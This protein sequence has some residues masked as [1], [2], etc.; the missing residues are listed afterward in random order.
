M[1]TDQVSSTPSTTQAVAAEVQSREPGAVPAAP[2]GGHAAAG[3]SD[4]F[5]VAA[6]VSR[7]IPAPFRHIEGMPLYRPLR[8]M[9]VDPAASQLEGAVARVNVPYEN[10]EP[11]PCG[12][13]FKVVG[14]DRDRDERY[15]P[16]DLDQPFAMISHGY[17]PSPSDPRFHQQ[18]VYAVCSAVYSTFRNALGRQVGWGFERTS[19]PERLELHP[20]AFRGLNAHY[21]RVAGALFFGYDLAGN[22]HATD[23][24]L[25]GGFVFTCLSHDVVVHELT[26]AML[27]GLRSHFSIPGSPDVAAFHE[28]FA[29]LVAI[30]QRLS[31]KELVAVA[32]RKSCG[33]LERA[34]LLTDLAKQLGHASGM[35][36]ALRSAL[37]L[38]QARRHS[39]D[40]DPHVMGSVLVAAVFEAYVTVFHR[41][42]ARYFRL[43]TQGTGIPARGELPADLAEVL[44][45]SVSKLASQF[46]SLIIRAIDFCPPVDIGFGEYLRALIT[47]DRDLVPDDRWGYREAL[48]DA[49]L[50]RDIYPRHVASL[51]EDALLWRQPCRK[52]PRVEQLDFAH[53]QFAGDPGSAAGP[54][55]LERQARVLGE[56]V[57]RPEYLGDFGLVRDGDPCLQGGVAELP[58]VASIRTARRVGPNGQIVFD[59]VAE[60][61]QRCLIPRT[62]ARAAFTAYGGAT[63]I[64]SPDGDIRY[65]I[66]KSVAGEGR[67][68]R[69][70]EFLLSG[71]A[72]KYWE[73][74][75]GRYALKGQF[76]SMLDR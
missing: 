22:G 65:A 50:R 34:T 31:Y 19:E 32:V 76:F 44:S 63:V 20:F 28:A 60:V 58:C 55:E 21:D 33:K 2:G 13:I 29:D 64:L 23:R 45:E 4:R 14:L 69:R 66:T 37:G 73:V 74:R 75:D 59:L 40:D 17:D 30:F 53:L 52:C 62:A 48:I 57:T 16:A 3:G 68:K 1:S 5:R 7:P 56:L 9:T 27:D 10:L 49:F 41:K 12:R 51:S 26:H 47:A 18:M 15:Q 67:L 43:A 8:I 72:E 71:Q 35:H 70:E 36:K 42:T 25:P 24:T 54:E 38:K 39:V 46:L 61:T 11:G 6:S